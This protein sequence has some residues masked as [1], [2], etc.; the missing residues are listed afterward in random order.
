MI[1]SSNKHSC[2]G[3]MDKQRHRQIYNLK[4]IFWTQIGL[5]FSLFIHKKTNLWVFG[6]AYGN[7][8]S[9]NAKYLFLYLLKSQSEIEPV[10]LTRNSNVYREIKKINGQV[11]YIHSLKGLLYGFT[12][13]NYIFTHNIRDIQNVI[14]KNAK[15]INLWHGMP[16][17]NLIDTKNTVICSKNIYTKMY[18]IAEKFMSPSRKMTY[19]LMILTSDFFR[20]HMEKT[21]LNAKKFVVTG[22]PR[23]DIFFKK[24]DKKEIFK[25]FGI[26]FSKR[27]VI[28]YLPTYRDKNT[29]QSFP[30]EI[31]NNF[32]DDL[33][34]IEKRHRNESLSSQN[35]SRK[36]FYNL[37]NKF[38]DTQ[39]L[40]L[41]TDILITDYSSVYFDFL[42]YNK[43]IIFYPY[44]YE[45]YQK[46]RNFAFSY[47]DTISS[48]AVYSKETLSKSIQKILNNKFQEKRSEHKRK[49]HKYQDGNSAERVFFEIQK[50]WK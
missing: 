28:T 42:L 16:L 30:L 50:L 47:N 41:I 19:D 46:I 4:S 2:D 48:Q 35:I 20:N 44:D 38:I 11:Y 9:G 37:S 5:F 43:P 45:I 25:K 1:L 24:V 8:F 17:K 3:L 29:T 49:Y 10:W 26:P 18:L 36:K 31:I 27:K 15:Q 33:I 23:S 12:A 32:E 6:E 40:L 22:E 7:Q 21:F 39:E 34:F 13:K 14:L